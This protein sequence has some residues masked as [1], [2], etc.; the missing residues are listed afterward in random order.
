[1]E[2]GSNKHN[3][4]RISDLPDCLLHHILSF[5]NP[6]QAVQTCI[7]S[8]RW[9]NIWRTLPTLTLTS[10]HFTTLMAFTKFYSNI[11]SLRDASAPL[12][13]LDFHRKGT[14]E[15]HL[16]KMILKYA[17]SHNVQRLKVDTLSNIQ[18]FPPSFFSCN[19][20]TSLNLNLCVNYNNNGKTL[21]PNSLNFPTLINLSLQNFIFG[22]KRDGHVDPFS[23]LTKLN[24]LVIYD[25]IVP[26]QKNLF[27]SSFT[28]ADLRIGNYCPC[29]GLKF[30]LS[31][32]S[33]YK[34]A[35]WGT[36][37][38][39]LCRSSMNNL[40]SVKHATIYADQYSKSQNTPLVLLNW[41]VEL[42]N[43][44]SLTVCLR[45]LEVL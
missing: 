38:Q 27:I 41:L 20:L 17:F 34:F 43:I 26:Y 9:K 19:T 28:L 22:V 35:F 3:K 15:P 45:T 24:S 44:E 42:A 18:Q 7:L 37:L 21:F 11:F 6:K 36:P 25:C 14:M 29:P 31:T 30:S 40:S 4:D 23:S 39:K 32:P 33:L 2:R 12:H 10:S 1:M 5:S 16:L 8:K 13:V